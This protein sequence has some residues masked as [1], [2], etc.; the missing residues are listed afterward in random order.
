MSFS[1]TYF[2]LL[3]NLTVLLVIVFTA[4]SYATGLFY[5]AELAEEYP[6][7]T[8]RVIVGLI[9]SICALHLLAFLFSSLSPLSLLLGLLTHACY[10]RLTSTFPYLPLTSPT[11]FLSL[12]LLASSQISWYLTLTPPPSSSSTHPYS[13]YT[14]YSQPGSPYHHRPSLSYTPPQLLA[15]FLLFVY[16]VPLAFFVTGSVSSQALPSMGERLREGGG[17]GRVGGGSGMGEEDGGEGKG[18]KGGGRGRWSLSGIRRLWGGE[19]G[20]KGGSTGRV[21]EGGGGGGAN[22]VGSG[23]DD[24]VRRAAQAYGDAGGPGAAP[25]YPGGGDGAGAGYV[26]SGVPSV[27]GGTSEGE[28]MGQQLPPTRPVYMRQRSHV[29]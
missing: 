8:R 10:Y 23:A 20:T 13:S 18:K 16:L 6:T 26:A 4:L 21:S 9:A 1:L 19:K 15:F 28:W 22:G 17:G 27:V 2:E 24:Y 14:P 29:S 5:L 25:W 7:N 12:A 11:F 3:C